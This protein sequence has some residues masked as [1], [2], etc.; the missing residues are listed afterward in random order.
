MRNT[1]A[2]MTDLETMGTSF[3][4]AIVSIGACAFDP[5]EEQTAADITERFYTTVTLQSCVT[6]GLQMSPDTIAWW[7]KQSKE[8]QMALFEEPHRQLRQACIEFRLWVESLRPRVTTLWANDPDFDYVI[9]R[10][11]F[12]AAGQM[13]PWQFWMHR[14]CRTIKDLAWPNGD[15]PDFR[16][17]TLHHRADD[18]AAAQATMVQAGYRK[19]VLGL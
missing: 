14:S 12:E 10:N 13:W 1:T 19:L 15:V 17:G 7:L 16:A 11:A 3:N 9:L 5:A 2:V 18:D 6:A 8:A 4:S